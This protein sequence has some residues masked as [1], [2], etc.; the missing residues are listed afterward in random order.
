MAVLLQHYFTVIAAGAGAGIGLFAAAL[1]ILRKTWREAPST[2]LG[3]FLIA[4]AFSAIDS[5]LMEM[6]AF[7]QA[8][9]L[10]GVTWQISL[11]LGPSLYAYVRKMADVDRKPWT[12]REVIMLLWPVLAIYVIA[13]PFYFIDDELQYRIYAEGDGVA[14]VL[15]IVFILFFLVLILGYL[16]AAIRV[17]P[18]HLNNMRQLF[19]NIEDRSLNWLRWVILIMLAAWLWA[20]IKSL[21]VPDDGQFAWLDMAS[22]LIEISWI[23]GFGYFGIRQMQVEPAVPVNRPRPDETEKYARS[24]L[25]DDRQSR[26][27]ERLEQVMTREALYRD[28]LLS[29]SSLARRVGVSPNHVSQTL[30][31][32]LGVNFFDYVNRLRVEEAARQIAETDRSILTIAHDVGFNSRSTFNA[33]VKKHTGQ[34]PS[35]F[36]QSSGA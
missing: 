1:M 32:H 15:Q 9:W 14:G 34:T 29:L 20:G 3:I 22:I 4:S 30:N 13:S 2:A 7:R 31:E 8:P 25:A 5:L 24:S 17:L 6:G 21:V 28:P 16:V 35:S 27:A 26:I 18:G 23:I 19:S 10:I 36:R 33:A 11:L 12:G